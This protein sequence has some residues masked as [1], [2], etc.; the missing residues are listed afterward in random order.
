M[1]IMIMMFDDGDDGGGEADVEDVFL[2]VS[3]LILRCG[4]FRLE[5]I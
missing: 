5:I 1:I 3:R 4:E 2:D